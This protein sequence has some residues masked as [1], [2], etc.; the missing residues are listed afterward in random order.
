MKTTMLDFLTAI[1]LGLAIAALAL[2]WFD[3]LIK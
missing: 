2:E 1:I 3:V